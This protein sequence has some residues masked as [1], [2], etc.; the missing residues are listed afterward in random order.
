MKI[1]RHLNINLLCVNRK[2]VVAFHFIL[3]SLFPF[4]ASSQSTFNVGFESHLYRDSTK[5]HLTSTTSSS[6]QSPSRPIRI[7]VWYPAAPTETSKQ[8]TIVEYI[9]QGNF[10]TPAERLTPDESKKLSDKLFSTLT[11]FGLER[12]TYTRYIQTTANAYSPA[13]PHKKKFPLLIL[14]NATNG[15][16][17]YHSPLAEQL[18][19]KGYVV[20][21]VA[22]Y[23]LNDTTDCG[24]DLPCVDLQLQDLRFV[25]RQS[26]ALSNVDS[27]N[28]GLLSWSFGGIAMTLLSGEESGVGAVASLDAATGYQYGY[29]LLR[30]LGM[31]QNP[32]ASSLNI[33]YL[34][35]GDSLPRAPKNFTYYDASVFKNKYL[36]KFPSLN[37]SDFCSFYFSIKN[38]VPGV[39]RSNA[40][41][42]G[43]HL[44][45]LL[46]RFFESSFLGKTKSFE[47]K[48]DE[49]INNRIIMGR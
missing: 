36:L 13:T 10:R 45:E 28:V 46:H 29:E 27:T 23:G 47:N 12:V 31:E 19:S 49:L 9:R 18:A 38:L 37:H 32:R 17:M 44:A 20:V 34:T 26:K 39:D 3:L 6:P 7:F 4:H 8:L 35:G 25:L 2:G 5:N 41:S 14:G 48:I 22:S 43:G 21:S 40:I 30:Q 24:Y 33:L 15:L 11:Y 1:C 42:S 16:A